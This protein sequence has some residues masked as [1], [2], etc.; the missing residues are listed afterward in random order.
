MESPVTH[1]EAGGVYLIFGPIFAE[2]DLTIADA[3]VLGTAATHGVGSATTAIGDQ[4]GDGVAEWIVGAPG[5]GERGTDA[6]AV[7][8]LYSPHIG[9]IDGG[10]GS[11]LSGV[12]AGD[13]AGATVL[14]A[15]D[16]NGDGIEDL[17]VG[18]PMAE[19]APPGSPHAGGDEPVRTDAGAVYVFLG[20]LIRDWVLDDADGIHTGPSESAYASSTLAALDDV[21]G[22]GLSD[23][24][25]GAP[26]ID[27]DLADMGAIFVLHGPAARS[28]SLAGAEARLDGD[29]GGAQAG[30]SLS[31]AG[32]TNDDGHADLLVGAPRGAGGA[33][34][35]TLMEGPWIGT[36]TLDEGV[37]IF[38]G[39]GG[40]RAGTGLD[41]GIDANGDGI[42]DILI[43]A[44]GEDSTGDAAGGIFLFLG[45]TD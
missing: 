20:P 41:G 25:V 33:G 24:A 8:V 34:R 27:G 23:F 22:D 38:R 16:L 18:A 11:T 14:A 12:A 4:N 30:A 31:A 28:G 1:D 35:V 17:V 45:A 7:W 21:D 43:G 36:H 2:T 9:T 15:G 29:E 37:A 39:A 42:P 19:S 44:P 26:G 40:D 3:T 13:R 5:D 10:A 6:G 32:D